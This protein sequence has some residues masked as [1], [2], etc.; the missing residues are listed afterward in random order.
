MSIQFDLSRITH[1]QFSW[2]RFL[3]ALIIFTATALHATVAI[4]QVVPAQ[5]VQQRDANAARRGGGTQADFDTLIELIRSTIAPN[6]WDDVGGEGSII[7]FPGGVFVDPSGVLRQI[8]KDV[9]GELTKVWK[10]ASLAAG[11]VSVQEIGKPSELRKVSLTRLERA[12]RDQLEQG[13]PPSLAMR[14]LAGLH[15]VDYLFVDREHSDVILAGPA[16]PW[17]VNQQGRVVDQV[18]GRP[19]LRLDD[20]VVAL[21]NAF[22]GSG[23]FVCAITPTQ[24]HLARTHEY[25]GRTSHEPLKPGGRDAWLDGLQLA[26]GRRERFGISA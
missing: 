20:L 15:R 4:A 16:G 13:Q 21:R 24:K 22:L 12:L 8:D 14:L 2:E 10:S 3:T 18:S 11:R 9:E 19:L 23:D 7:G 1:R 26:L 25:I 6:T 17:T 5:D